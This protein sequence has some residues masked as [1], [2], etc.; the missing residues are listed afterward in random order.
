LLKHLLPQQRK[1][2]PSQPLVLQHPVPSQQRKRPSLQKA[3]ASQPIKRQSL[4]RSNPHRTA[5]L[6]LDDCEIEF[7]FEDAIHRGYNSRLRI[8]DDEGEEVL[9]EHIRWRLFL[10]RQLALMKHREIHG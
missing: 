8:I 9:P 4:L 10:I 2:K 6:N 7:V 5:V 3:T 1:K